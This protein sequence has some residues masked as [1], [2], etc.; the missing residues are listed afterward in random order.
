M[1]AGAALAVAILLSGIICPVALGAYSFGWWYRGRFERKE[2]EPQHDDVEHDGERT[3]G[4]L[5]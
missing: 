5:D 4:S 1:T 2:K 3:A